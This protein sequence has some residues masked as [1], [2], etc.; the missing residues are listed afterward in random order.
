MGRG[1]GNLKTEDILKYSKS[2]NS[3][4]KIKKY[5]LKLKNNSNGVQINITLMLQK[6]NSSNICT[7]SFI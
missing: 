1:P 3:E 4:F 5:F 6:Q 2:H 7:K